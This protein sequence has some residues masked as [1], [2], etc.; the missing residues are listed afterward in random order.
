MANTPCDLALDGKRSLVEK[1]D[2][3]RNYVY[4]CMYVWVAFFLVFVFFV[5]GRHFGL[6]K[7]AGGLNV[8]PN[9]ATLEYEL[10]FLPSSVG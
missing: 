6:G 4:K 1:V 5:S 7:K 2:L 9:L 10:A 8:F 3:Q